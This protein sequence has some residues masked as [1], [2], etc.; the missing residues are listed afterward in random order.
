M[1]PLVRRN[2]K[3][4]FLMILKRGF[5]GLGCTASHRGLG[6]LRWDRTDLPYIVLGWEDDAIGLEVRGLVGMGMEL[7]VRR[8]RDSS[9]R[10]LPQ[11]DM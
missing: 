1:L 6:A 9:S 4:R 2:W 8:L 5:L 11:N 7:G 3:F 10:G